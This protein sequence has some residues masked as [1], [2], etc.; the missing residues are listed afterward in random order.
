MNKVRLLKKDELAD[1]LRTSKQTITNQINQGK[2]G[3]CVPPAIRL[4]RS[5]RWSEETVYQWLRERESFGKVCSKTSE[6]T[7]SLKIQIN[8]V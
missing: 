1:V 7:S 4:G 5:Y 2:E 3:I 8:R 6:T